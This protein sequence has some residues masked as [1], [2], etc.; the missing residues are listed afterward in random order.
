M[1]NRF[2]RHNF[3]WRRNFIRCS[4]EVLGQA[5]YCIILEFVE[6]VLQF[7]IQWHVR[8]GPSLE[9]S[10]LDSLEYQRNLKIKKHLTLRDG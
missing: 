1:D 3:N 10:I 2:S 9:D 4:K 8:S 5:I 7:G 6:T